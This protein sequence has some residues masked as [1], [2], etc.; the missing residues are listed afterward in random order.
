RFFETWP[1]A[2]NAALVL[3]HTDE[4]RLKAEVYAKKYGHLMLFSD[5][6]PQGLE[7]LKLGLDDGNVRRWAMNGKTLW[8]DTVDLRTNATFV[9]SLDLSKLI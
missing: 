5:R 7:V 8:L 9:W 2:A 4:L 6:F 3:F 1:V